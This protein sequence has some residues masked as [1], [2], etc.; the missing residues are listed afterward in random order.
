MIRHIHPAP[1]EVRLYTPLRFCSSSMLCPA[2][3][4]VKSLSAIASSGFHLTMTPLK[5]ADFPSV[6]VMPKMLVFHFGVRMELGSFRRVKVSSP[7]LVRTVLIVKSSMSDT[8]LGPEGEI[9][10]MSANIAYCLP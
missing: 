10:Y 3:R 6:D 2:L 7:V 9:I 4:I 1:L 8:V 5:L